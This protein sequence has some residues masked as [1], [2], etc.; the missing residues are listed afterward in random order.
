MTRRRLAL[1]LYFC[2]VAH[3][4]ACQIL[5]KAFLKS[6]KTWQRP[7]GCWRYFSPRIL[8][9][10]IFSVVLTPSC[11]E[12]CLFFS[13]DRLRLRLQSV[14]YDRQYDFTWVAD[15][16]DRSVVLAL[17]QVAFLGKCDDQELG[18]RGWPFSCRPN[19][20]ADCRDSSDY[21][22]SPR[23]RLPFLGN[24]MTKDLALLLSARS[25]WKLL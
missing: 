9:L 4:A 16:A 7:C 12:A 18:P 21:F 10:K 17:L 3:K 2:M 15:E 14:Q 19:L 1:M 22:F 13:N 11:S 25:C 24:V 23:C 8:R 6:T 5:S 20:D